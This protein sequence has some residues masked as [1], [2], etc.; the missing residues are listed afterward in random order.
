M[1]GGIQM[2]H[3]EQ[4]IEFTKNDSANVSAAKLQRPV[5]WIVVA[6]GFLAAG[7]AGGTLLYA[8]KPDLAWTVPVVCFAGYI[9]AFRRGLLL[10]NPEI[11]RTWRQYMWIKP[12][13]AGPIDRRMPVGFREGSFDSPKDAGL[14]GPEVPPLPQ[15]QLRVL[16]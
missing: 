13:G 5:V 14:V 12:A 7:L 8:W 16:R 3:R 4:E 2:S 1:S 10:W 9:L 11:D 15:R 6:F